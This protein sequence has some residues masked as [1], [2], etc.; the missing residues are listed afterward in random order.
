G[1][2]RATEY[3]RG[4]NAQGK[5]RLLPRRSR[6]LAREALEERGRAGEGAARVAAERQQSAGTRGPPSG[7]CLSALPGRGR[8]LSRAELSARG[9]GRD[10]CGLRHGPGQAGD[11]QPLG[12]RARRRYQELDL[13]REIYGG[14][15]AALF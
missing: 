10:S 5:R 4:E 15:P 2:E 9:K 3:D 14:P 12:G 7:T 8:R 13:C 1:G 11:G 6:R